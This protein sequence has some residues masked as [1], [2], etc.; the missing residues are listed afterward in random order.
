DERKHVLSAQPPDGLGVGRQRQVGEV[1]QL[2]PVAKRELHVLV[3]LGEED[4]APVPSLLAHGLEHRAVVAV[5]D[6]VPA[7]EGTRAQTELARVPGD[8]AD[9][10]PCASEAASDSKT[11]VEEAEDDRAPHVATS[12][13]VR[14]SRAAISSRPNSRSASARAVFPM[15]PP[16][17]P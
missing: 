7:L 5:A 2:V 17:S 6:Y 9:R 3:A 15:R 12:S 16:P 8:P 4:D 1:A 14:A 10:N 13:S 11:G